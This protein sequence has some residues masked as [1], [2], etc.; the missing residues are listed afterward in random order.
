[1]TDS[2]S[3]IEPPPPGYP[4]EKSRR[5]FRKTAWILAGL[6]PIIVLLAPLVLVASIGSVG[7]SDAQGEGVLLLAAAIPPFVLAVAMSILMSRHRIPTIR[8][9]SRKARFASLDRRA[10]AKLIDAPLLIGPFVVGALNTRISLLPFYGPS[11]DT[12]EGFALILP[13]I[14][15]VT[16]SVV[17]F[18]LFSFTEGKWGVTPGKWLT[19]IRVRSTDLRPCGMEYALVRNFLLIIDGLVFFLVG[20][21]AAALSEKWQR[22]GDMAAHTVVVEIPSRS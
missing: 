11:I 10:A 7:S 3:P 22:V 1:M 20:I 19:R 12:P 13:G 14:L 6:F 5:E 16:L 4:S 15:G 2:Q 17:F 9:G 21:M 18:L 8:V